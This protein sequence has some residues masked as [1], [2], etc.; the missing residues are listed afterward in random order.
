[1]SSPDEG[2]G[3]FG[4]SGVIRGP[5][6]DE[7][8]VIRDSSLAVELMTADAGSFKDEQAGTTPL[9][10][11]RLIADLPRHRGSGS[12]SNVSAIAVGGNALQIGCDRFDVRLRQVAETV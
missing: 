7:R 11:R 5:A 3:C 10:G 6:A 4:A 1:M 9:S 12:R 2:L 8:C